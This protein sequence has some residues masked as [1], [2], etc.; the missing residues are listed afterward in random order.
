MMIDVISSNRRSRNA[1]QKIVFFVR[2]PIGSIE[3]NGIR[4]ILLV[5]RGHTRS[6]LFQ[7][8][9]PSRGLEPAAETD[10]GMIEPLGMAGE[11]EREPAFG[12]QKVAVVTGEI[13]IID[14]QDFVI[15]H[16]ERR[17]A[18]IGAVRAHG[19]D[20]LHL[21]RTCVIAVGS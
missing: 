11:V 15:A 6:R 17:L 20:V 5:Y 3:P 10:Q 2:G 9:F 19:G 14:A 1:P 18:A 7:S 16:A 8:L 4:P 13:A 21:P 12:T